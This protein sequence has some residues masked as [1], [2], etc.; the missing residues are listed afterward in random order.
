[1]KI[2]FVTES[3]ALGD[4]KQSVDVVTHD[5]FNDG[6]VKTHGAKIAEGERQIER[7][8]YKI[9]TFNE[10][11]QEN[12]E[13]ISGLENGYKSIPQALRDALGVAVQEVFADKLACFA[14]QV[15]ALGEERK[16][17]STQLEEMC[18]A[19][20]EVK[21]QLDA[22][23]GQCAESKAHL[24]TLG[25]QIADMERMKN[26]MRED[27]SRQVDEFKKSVP[28]PKKFAHFLFQRTTT[29]TTE[30]K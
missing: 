7:L 27:F 15:E 16:R 10:R 8:W 9:E 2:T 13:K 22:L 3:H 11:V 1:M 20:E 21:S 18:Q 19:R 24:E 28:V 6:I 26:G 5:E 30:E 17:I 23:R 12:F 14:K 25:R 4:D 29:T